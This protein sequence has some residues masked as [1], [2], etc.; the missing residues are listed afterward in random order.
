MRGFLALPKSIFGP[1]IVAASPALSGVNNNEPSSSSADISLEIL[2]CF[3]VS[4]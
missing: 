2:K 4:L 3:F 1:T